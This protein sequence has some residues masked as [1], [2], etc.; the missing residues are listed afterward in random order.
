MNYLLLIGSL[1][2]LPDP[3]RAAGLSKITLY[4]GEVKTLSCDACQ[5]MRLSRKGLVEIY[6]N[7][8]NKEIDVVALKKGFVTAIFPFSQNKV[9]TF[10]FEVL[11]PREKSTLP[12]IQKEGSSPDVEYWLRVESSVES[13]SQAQLS[14]LRNLRPVTETQM[15][16]TLEFNRSLSSE[17]N[18]ASSEVRM[19][20][21]KRSTVFAGIEKPYN[22]QEAQVGYVMFKKIGLR[23]EVQP[24]FHKKNK[25]CL[26]YLVSLS[27]GGQRKGIHS[28]T[29]EGEACLTLK[30]RSLVGRVNCQLDLKESEFLSFLEHI[31]IISPLF[32]KS[33]TLKNDMKLRIY[34]LVDK[35]V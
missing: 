5:T 4:Q 8:K 18:I 11:A 34:F 31:P 12:E 20:M 10:L 15:I 9:R 3:A 6:F 19:M 2:I 17:K 21:G 24:Y 1:L 13:D 29:L 26:K 28:N 33:E 14:D 23:I 32:R 22:S 7:P 25:V 16:D 35:K 27:G 30:Q